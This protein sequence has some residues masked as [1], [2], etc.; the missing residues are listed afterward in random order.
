MFKLTD[1]F[2]TAPS[3]PPFIQSVS[4]GVPWNNLPITREYTLGQLLD[5][6]IARCGPQDAVVYA[7]RGFRLTWYEFGIEVDRLAR[8][9]MALGIKRGEKIALWA[10]NVPHWIVLMF[11]A[12]KIGAILLPLNTNYKTAEID[13]ALSQSDTENIFVIN[14]YRDTDYVQILN[15]LIPELRQQP[16]GE[17]KSARYPHLK[18]VMFLGPEKHRGM[19]SL[20][21]VMALSVEV[22]QEEYL[23]RQAECDVNDVVNMQYTSGTTGF[24]KGVQLTHRNIGND[25][26][27]IGACQNF[28]CRDRVCIPVPL[29]HC[30]GCVLGV[31]SCVNHGS[32]MV[33]LEKY[34]PVNV[35]MS[36]EQEHCTAVYGV[37][38]MYIAILDHPLF[39][40]FN[41]STLRTGI[42]S[43]STCPVLRMQQT[44]DRMNMREITNPYGLTESGPVMTMTRYFETSIE[45]K[46]QTIGQAL[47]GV[48]VAIINPETQELCAI[49]EDGEICCRGFNTMKGY[50]NMPEQTAKCID[51]RGWLHSG[52]I[53]HMDADGYYYITSRLKDL[54]IRGG[55]N[56]SPREVEDF[57]THLEGVQDV[58]VVGCPSKKYG[59]QPAAFIIRQVG[60]DLSE[61]DVQDYCRNKIS[62]FKI[63]KY[64]HFM[65][66]FPMTASQKIQKYKL[67]E[68][69][70]QLWPDA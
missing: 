48:E 41:F 21:E 61:E 9:L 23:Q 10:T 14:G 16:R 50:Y 54:I 20:N 2:G 36:I 1:P 26:F 19:Y 68:L 63:P 8:G 40:R 33:M 67:R 18:R 13:F 24:P 69:A 65:D 66:E 55:E 56:I 4:T 46:C 45:R 22:S 3:K 29:F 5:Q 37:P 62:W 11:A 30:F 35:M 39:N 59:E 25:G 6:T 57:L 58:Q 47:P 38:T 52:D 28:S 53:G 7:D 44:V 51:E 12:A 17:L 49:G 34:D 27:W 64:I 70:A 31:M 32:T 42:M 43:G 60:S 15:D